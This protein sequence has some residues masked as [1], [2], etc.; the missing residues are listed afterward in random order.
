MSELLFK[1]LSN[2]VVIEE[3]SKKKTDG[4]LFVPDNAKQAKQE[5]SIVDHI[6]IAISEEKDEKGNS[7]IRNV[8]IGDRVLFSRGAH[9]IAIIEGKPYLVVRE[10]SIIGIFTGENKQLKPQPTFVN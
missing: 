10:T 6:V 2:Y 5:L 9:D 4:G 7:L 8:K 3:I 1:P